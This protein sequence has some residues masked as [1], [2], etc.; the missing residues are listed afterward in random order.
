MY[1]L[2]FTIQQQVLKSLRNKYSFNVFSPKL[3]EKLT[4]KTIKENEH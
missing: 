4:N 2:G 1:K 3:H